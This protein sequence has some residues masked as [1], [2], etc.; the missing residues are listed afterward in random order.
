MKRISSRTSFVL[1]LVFVL[2]LGLR[3]AAALQL[4]W[5][6]LANGGTASASSNWNTTAGNT[7]W[8]DGTT[9]VVW[10]QTSITL[11]TQGAI[12]NGPDAAPGTYVISEDSTQV[13]VTNLTINNS[14]YTFAGPNAIYL[15]ANDFLSVAA[16]KTVT[17]NCNLAGSGTSPCWTLGAGATMNVVGNL[18]SGQQVRLAGA[19]NSA[20]N[21][22]GTANGPAIMFILAPVNV[23]SGSLV[24]SASFYI[25]YTQTLPAPNSITYNTG[26]LT[27]SGS[28]TIFTVNGNILIIGRA[29]GTGT[30]NVT[31]GTVTVGNLTANRNLAICYD[32]SAGASGTVNVSGGTLNV[33]SSSMLGNQLA[34]F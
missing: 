4:I 6:P 30:L 27:I 19:A 21:L 22:T 5:D 31:D 8:F 23:T 15:G 33:G 20:F 14:G 7:I 24:P 29:G 12:F 16:G 34:F 11:P 26:T 2:N 13:A 17:F 9:D 10:S 1:S 18:T 32:G 3:T 28:S 25:G